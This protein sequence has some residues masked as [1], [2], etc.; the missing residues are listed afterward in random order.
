MINVVHS[1]LISPVEIEKCG[2]QN[3]LKAR[4]VYLFIISL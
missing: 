3:G 1:A 4:S 2:Q